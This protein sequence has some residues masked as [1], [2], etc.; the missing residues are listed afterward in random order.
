MTV[1]EKTGRKRY[2]H[3]RDANPDK[4][5]RLVQLT[6]DSRVVNYHGMAALRIRHNQ[7]QQLR[8]TSKRVGIEIDMVSGTLKAL[9]DKLS[10]IQ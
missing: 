7:L 8:E 6:D 10:N 9:R 5:R 4:L 2:V 3:F 1:K